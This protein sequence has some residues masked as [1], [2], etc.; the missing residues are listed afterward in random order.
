MEFI[1]KDSKFTT[2]IFE[3]P[4]IKSG[5]RG[6]RSCII[7][8][9]VTELNKTAG[10]KYKKGTEWIT[11][12]PVKPAFIAFKVSHLNVNELWTFLSQC[13][14]SRS[15]FRKCFYGALKVVDRKF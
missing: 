15:G 9:F 11:I 6:V 1:D 5:A 4:K 14:Q 13:R 7:E 8:D 3:L 12:K 2:P 10:E